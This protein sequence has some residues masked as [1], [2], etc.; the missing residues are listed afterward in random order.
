MG[1]NYPAVQARLEVVGAREARKLLMSELLSLLQDAR[2]YGDMLRAYRHPRSAVRPWVLRKARMLD[3]E[4]HRRL[5]SALAGNLEID[6]IRRECDYDNGFRY[7]VSTVEPGKER[8][9]MWGGS[10][11]DVGHDRALA[12]LLSFVVLFSDG[13]LLNDINYA[14]L[15]R[16]LDRLERAGFRNDAAVYNLASAVHRFLC[17]TARPLPGCDIIPWFSP[18]WFAC[19]D[20]AKALQPTPMSVQDDGTSILVTPDLH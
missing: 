17:Q 7:V 16:R 3:N 14:R 15:E 18:L 1:I 19:V 6:L 10:W 4:W 2:A 20:A 8:D 13:L 5:Q 11:S 9:M 12:Q